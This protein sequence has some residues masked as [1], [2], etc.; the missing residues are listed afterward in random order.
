M[1]NLRKLQ[2]PKGEKDQIV[3][4]EY[5]DSQK[6]F[7]KITYHSYLMNSGLE[8]DDKKENKK[9][10]ISQ[11][12]FEGICETIGQEI[13]MENLQE[14]IDKDDGF[15]SCFGFCY[16]DKSY[17]KKDIEDYLEKIGQGKSEESIRRARDKIFEYSACN[18][19][20]YFVTLTLDNQKTE[21]RTDL[22][23]VYKT[24]S[25]WFRDYKKKHKDFCYLII[26]EEHKKE[27]EKG[28]KGWHFHGL[29]RGI[30]KEDLTDFKEIEKSR[31]LPYYIVNKIKK[32]QKIYNWDSWGKRWG[33]ND[34]EPIG[35]KEA[36]E[37][38]ITKYCTKELGSSVKDA[39]AQMYYVS[40]GFKTAEIIAKGTYSGKVDAKDK[41]FFDYVGDYCSV[42]IIKDRQEL[43]KLKDALIQK[44][45]VYSN[46][47]VID[48][49]T[50]EIVSC[51]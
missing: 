26:P 15:I 37:K 3:I 40:K 18:D 33:L 20:D 5:K 23:K 28:E 16:K 48:K 42:K 9:R 1:V 7:W 14:I 21:F 36:V 51:L 4:K 34:I 25:Q 49:E 24:I 19:F 27:D 29:V 46:N 11:K 43:D 32:G 2:A 44:N 31:P 17:T 47:L 45:Y 35:N 13:T 22:K 41:D 39:N 38:Y 50:G 30:P 12:T 10:V 6:T 8:I